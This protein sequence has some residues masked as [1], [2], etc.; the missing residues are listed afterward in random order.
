MKLK[1]LLSHAPPHTVAGAGNPE[2]NDVCQDSRKCGPGSAFVAVKGTAFDAHDVLNEVAEKNPAALVVQDT[3]K[4][5]ASYSGPV[6][7]S[8][9]TRQLLD[10]LAHEA[11]GRPSDKMLCVGVTGTNGKTTTTNILEALLNG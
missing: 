8:E 10:Y 1:D 7:K 5:P 3:R 6:V 2:I 4:V 11:A 9:N